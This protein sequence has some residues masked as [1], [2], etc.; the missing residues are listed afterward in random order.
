MSD[1]HARVHQWL[2]GTGF[3]LEMQAASAFRTAGFEVRQAS[4]YSDPQSEKGREI[5]VLAMDPDFY[6]FVE[7]SVVVECKSSSSPWVVLVS[8]TTLD[9][10]NRVH[11]MAVSSDAAKSAVFD[12]LTRQAD[13]A[14]P[15][16]LKLDNRCGYG[17]RQAFTKDHDPAYG[18]CVNVLKAC[19]AVSRD[20]TP[21]GVPRLAF[22]FPLL[23]VDAPTYECELV[24]GGDLCIKEVNSAQVLFSAYFPD[25]ISS[26]IRV[27][28]AGH[29]AAT[30]GELKS[31]ADE[32]REFLGFKQAEMLKQWTRS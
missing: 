26:R 27:V 10:Y 17:L 24:E 12:E 25:P 4:T 11:A 3:P 2:M 32:L 9:G 16:V 7:I 23:V 5:D 31:N 28:R 8:P 6:G 19:A 21:G 15:K 29:L 20:R 1:L 14:K 18:A 13:K 30:A 22:A